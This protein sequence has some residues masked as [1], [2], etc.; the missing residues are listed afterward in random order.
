MSDG[1]A[2]YLY[3]PE[4]GTRYAS[5]AAAKVEQALRDAGLAVGPD[6]E[7]TQW[8]PMRPS[9]AL[10]SWAE[11]AG[12]VHPTIEVR[13]H[14]DAEE[15]S[16]TYLPPRG[17]WSR[18]PDCE[19]L[20]PTHGMVI[21]TIADGTE[22]MVELED[23]PSCGVDFQP[24]EWPRSD[25]RVVFRSRFIVGIVADSYANSKPTFADGCPQFVTCV[26]EVLARD[27]LREVFVAW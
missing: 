3:V 13:W 25:D 19:K 11:K 6:G 22:E 18:C 27:E 24:Y 1:F 10:A 15:I 17:P 12:L 16:D 5:D 9:G 21:E 23:C 8:K 2:R 26:G 7:G 20:V 4:D 14:D